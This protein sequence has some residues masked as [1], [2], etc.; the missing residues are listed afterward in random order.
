MMA[1][2]ELT[3]SPSFTVHDSCTHEGAPESLTRDVS[4]T[5]CYARAGIPLLWP[6][7]R[8]RTYWCRLQLRFW[9]SWITNAKRAQPAGVTVQITNIIAQLRTT[10]LAASI[11]FCTIQLGFMLEFQYE[12]F[13]AG[14]RT[15]AHVIHLKLVDEMD[16]SREF[17]M[18]ESADPRKPIGD[19]WRS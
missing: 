4:L 14:V 3:G 15:G 1:L 17:V 2:M 19:C 8:L 11:R 13:Y 9:A 10:D 6:E 7:L 18:R 16:P 5:T 12:D